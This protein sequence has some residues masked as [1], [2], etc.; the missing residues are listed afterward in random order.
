[1]VTGRAAFGAAAASSGVITGCSV[2][3]VASYAIGNMVRKYNTCEVNDIR[4]MQTDGTIM[5]LFSQ[6]ALANFLRAR[7]GGAK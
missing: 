1:M 3:K 2:Q 5:S 4:A 7:T 6:V